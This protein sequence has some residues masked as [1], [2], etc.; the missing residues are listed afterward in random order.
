MTSFQGTISHEWSRVQRSKYNQQP[1]ATKLVCVSNGTPQA[2]APQ[3]CLYLEHP[4]TFLPPRQGYRR[5]MPWFHS[6][7]QLPRQMTLQGQIRWPQTGSHVL[8]LSHLLHC[9]GSDHPCDTLLHISS[10]GP[11]ASSYLSLI[12]S[13][14]ECLVRT[15][16]VADTTLSTRDGGTEKTDAAPISWIILFTMKGEQITHIILPW[17]KKTVTSVWKF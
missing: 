6:F 4:R 1:G 5:A 2:K 11:L 16:Y 10:I 8:V 7:S 13:W 12:C 9:V 14:T 17:P 3:L 15:Y